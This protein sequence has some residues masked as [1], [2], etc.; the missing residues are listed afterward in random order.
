MIVLYLRADIVQ[1][2]GSLEGKWALLE[3][4]LCSYLSQ[5]ERTSAF[6]SGGKVNLGNRRELRVD[7]R[8]Y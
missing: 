6:C 4:L 8:L 1:G 7:M 5:I 2:C 3:P